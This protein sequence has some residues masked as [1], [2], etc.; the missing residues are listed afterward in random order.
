MSSV[1][2]DFNQR[3]EPR[4]PRERVTDNSFKWAAR[5]FALSILAM[6]IWIAA[7]VA[8]RAVPAIAE[9]GLGFWVNSSWNPP[10]EEYGVLPAI[11][12]TIVSSIIALGIS[13]PIGLGVA[14]F[15]S[16][17]YLPPKVQRIFVFLVE[18]LAAVPSVVYGLWG[19]FVL[20]PFLKEI[21]PL[22]GPGMLPAA[23]VLA[24]MVLPIIAAISRD[25]ISSVPKDLRQAAVG[26]G[27]TRWEAIILVILPA[28]SS[29]II[30]GIMLALGRALG[31]TMAATML[32][33]NA[34]K[35]NLSIFE[36]SNTIASL[37][38]NQFAEASGLQVAALM[39]AALIL[40]AM[41]LVVN[42]LAQML[43][44]RLQRI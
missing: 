5:I 2:G 7:I 20:I 22:K 14:I 11:Y 39:Y 19:I 24:V 40:F 34:N 13:V 3:L 32:I 31:E 4:P 10:R 26:L 17:D 37:L 18:L 42:I 25:A 30:G 28:A 36:P 35:V 21:T 38:A 33:G 9:F 23:L 8:I 1:S 12:G 43:V 15:L 29:G 27:A 6:L 44:K 41:T 16:E